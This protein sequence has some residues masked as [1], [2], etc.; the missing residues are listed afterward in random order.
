MA[1][2]DGTYGY[3]QM[4]TGGADPYKDIVFEPQVDW[5][6]LDSS[7]L[8]R[9]EQVAE[10][11]GKIIDVGS[12]YRSPAYSAS[13]GGYSNDPH[14]RGLAVD[15]KADGQ[16][17]GYVIPRSLLSQYGLEGGNVPASEGGFYHG[18]PDV[19]HIQWP[20]SGV[21]KSLHAT[22]TYASSGGAV[23]GSGSSSSPSAPVTMDSAQ[24]RADFMAAI[25][26]DSGLDPR[27]VWAW[28][29]QEGSYKGNGVGGWNY[30]NVR[31]VSGDKHVGVSSGNFA[32]FGNE[33]DAIATTVNVLHQSNMRS[34]L[35]AAHADD[36]AGQEIA[37]IGASPWGT[38]ATQFRNTYAS[39]FGAA[40]LNDEWHNDFDHL[41]ALAKATGVG[42]SPSI[43]DRATGAIT[44]PITN[45]AD[46]AGA[47]FGKAFDFATSWR[48]AEV[49]GG[50]ILLVVGL[51]LL[52]RHF[53]MRPPAPAPVNSAAD[54]AASTF[55][56]EPGHAAYASS[57]RS[58]RQGTGRRRTR[59]VVLEADR[60][61]PSRGSSGPGDEIPF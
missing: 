21:D 6:H 49:V 24:A 29:Q 20:G 12:G 34:I 48:L 11:S 14:A 10:A 37:A 39:I 23:S 33:Q 18:L 3:P 9:L 36:T 52:G 8:Q 13:V 45:A 22:S 42:D 40:S 38:G 32:L 43:I 4:Q 17:V 7:F 50:F 16:A 26:K 51:V 19:P 46:A 58:S 27:V 56:F 25:A 41:A 30:L 59:S 28:I 61:A 57:Q 47:A 31:P 15:A 1:G 2:S 53:G 60:P 54:T 55:A 35:D 5:V 44:S